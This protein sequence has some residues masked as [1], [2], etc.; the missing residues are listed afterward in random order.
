MSTLTKSDLNGI[1]A[2][3]PSAS[4]CLR[5]DLVRDA[6]WPTTSDL[7]LDQL[8]GQLVWV[9]NEGLFIVIH[10]RKKDAR[11]PRQV[12]CENFRSHRQI[13][14]AYGPLGHHYKG[15]AHLRG[16]MVTLST[17]SPVSLETYCHLSARCASSTLSIPK[18][19]FL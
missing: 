9:M 19:C 1:S 4:H 5:G 11:P 3:G 6:S 13:V 2:D 10:T 14:D 16:G 12:L 8:V 7:E 15:R 17:T 18:P